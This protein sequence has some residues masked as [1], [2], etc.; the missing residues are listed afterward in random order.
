MNRHSRAAAFVVD[1]DD[2]LYPQSDYLA[3][4]A[5][6]V[7]CAA[8]RAGI[9]PCRFL[10]AFMAE[11]AAGSDR[12]GTIDR[13]LDAVGVTAELAARVLPGLVQAFVGYQPVSL[14]P[15]PGVI[16]ALARLRAAGPVACLTDGRPEIQEAKLTA[17]SLTDQFDAVVVT[18]R[19]GGRAARKPNPAG[20]FAVAHLFGVR[21]AD[22]VAIGDRPDKDV[23][24]AAAV[25]ARAIRVRQ[26]EYCNAPDHP[27]ACAYA[28][29]FPEAVTVSLTLA[30]G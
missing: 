8:A 27:P 17:L 29:T 21:P 18:D 7:A 30:A 28:Q 11:L 25:G 5:S 26:G 6:A 1:L 10:V 20:L 19:L 4:A 12:G 14:R 13:A 3:G 24:A 15:Y 22:L 2:T 16:E 9:P 23:A